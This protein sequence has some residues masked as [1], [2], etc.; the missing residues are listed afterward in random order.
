MPQLTRVGDISVGTCSCCCPGCPHGWVSVHI[1]GR[2]NVYASGKNVMGAPH[3]IG[4]SSCPHCPTSF[5]V[6]GSGTV[7][8]EG[9]KAHRIGDVHNVA[10][11]TGVVV[12]GDS[13]ILVGG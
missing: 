6:T 2:P 5:S 1:Q 12:S 3:D 9:K 11:G 13:R 7:N 4:S 10:C 8:V